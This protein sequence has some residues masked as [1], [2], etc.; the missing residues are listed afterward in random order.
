MP[1]TQPGVMS[2][3]GKVEAAISYHPND[4]L[5]KVIVAA[6]KS[7][8]VTN[9]LLTFPRDG[10]AVWKKGYDYEEAL[11]R[12]R[13]ALQSIVPD[14]QLNRPIVLTPAQHA[15]GYK[16]KND[17]EVVFVLPDAAL[18]VFHSIAAA[19]V[20]MSITVRGM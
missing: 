2:P 9:E 8:S 16:K 1:Q 14:L 17:D 18:A 19:T 4:D 15:K 7:D 13:K 11:A 6:W 10:P 20:A 12:T 3:K 5:A